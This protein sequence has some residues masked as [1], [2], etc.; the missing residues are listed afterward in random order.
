MPSYRY[1]PFFDHPLRE[2]V[3]LLLVKELDCKSIGNHML[4]SEQIISFLKKRRKKLDSEISDCGMSTFHRS[5]QT[6]VRTLQP[7]SM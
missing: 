6:S 1:F 5:F 4:F 2:Q 7:S 3:L